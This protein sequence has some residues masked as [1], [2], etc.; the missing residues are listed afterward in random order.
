MTTPRTSRSPLS[1][2]LF[3]VAAGLVL[4]VAVSFLACP[5]HA[6]DPAAVVAAKTALQ[7]AVDRGE[8]SAM[9]AARAQFAALSAS[10]PK[11]ASLHYWVA[12]ATWRAVP[13]LADD[14]AK[15]EQARKLCKEAIERCEQALAIAPKHADAMALR[16]GL[17]GLWLSFD[18]G[19]AMTLGMEMEQALARARELEPGNPR[20]ALLDGVNTLHKPA[21]VGGGADKARARFDESIALYDRSAAGTTGPSGGGGDPDVLAWGRDDACLWAGRAAMKEKDYAAA[22]AYFQRALAV[23][24]NN[25]WVKN[26]LLPAAEKQLAEKGNS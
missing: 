19:A 21:F 7:S 2:T 25:G 10:E 6:A 14:K 11:S 13:L 8:P 17:Q 18:P 1:T 15:K 5:A 16:A 20:V 26:S 24:P 23:N 12:L 22:R 4:S 9:L 3:V